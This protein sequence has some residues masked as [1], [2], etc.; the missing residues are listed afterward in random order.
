ML[1]GAGARSVLNNIITPQLKDVENDFWSYLAR[2][3]QFLFPGNE[4]L[5]N[6]LDVY[7]GEPIRY[8]DPMTNMVNAFLPAF[9]SNGGMEPWRQWL[10]E[11]GWDGLQEL[12]T[13]KLNGQPIDPEAQQWINNYIGAGLKNKDG[14]PKPGYPLVKKIEEMMNHPD[15]YWDKKIKQYK[16]GRGNLEQKDFPI[17]KLVVHQQLNELHRRA[18]QAGWAAYMET[19]KGKAQTKEG[20]YRD[21]I[22]EQLRTGNVKG[23][24]ETTEQ[25]LDIISITK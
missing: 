5:K 17:K 21:V 22:N 11:T 14:S 25:M 3:N 2:N 1:P 10:L 16:I 24:K 23:A 20:Q 9:K 18:R 12:Q 4:F 8:F 19:Q 15:G 7:T 6:S 13:N